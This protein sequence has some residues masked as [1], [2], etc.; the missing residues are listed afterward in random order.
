M[1]T[2]SPTRTIDTT[3]LPA[4]VKQPVATVWTKANW[5]DAWVVRVDLEVQQTADVMPPELSTATLRYRYG[6]VLLPGGSIARTQ[7]P[8]TAFG[9]YVLIRWTQPNAE[10]GLL[11]DE[12]PSAW[13]LGYADPPVTTVIDRGRDPVPPT[14][15]QTIPCFGLLRMLQLSH[16]RET[17][18]ADPAAPLGED[19]VRHPTGSTFN[20]DEA[21]NR[22]DHGA[23]DR[24]TFARSGKATTWS[25]R[26]IVKH[27]IKHHAPKPLSES[28]DP[29]P[30]ELAG[31]TQIP[32]W[33]APTMA[34][35]NRPVADL[36]DEILTESRGLAW[37]VRPV[38]EIE[39][40]VPD[41]T[42]IQI[43]VTTRIKQAIPLEDPDEVPAATERLKFVVQADP[44]IRTTL[45]DDG[46]GVVNQV[47]VEGPREIGV[48]T[49]TMLEME[50]G[51]DDEDETD[52][53]TAASDEEGYDD[54]KQFE[55]RRWNEK[56]RRREKFA[57]VFTALRIKTTWSGKVNE[58]ED[59]VFVRNE[60]EGQDEEDQ[61]EIYKPN[62]SNLVVLPDCRLRP[63][64][65]Y[66]GPINDV[67]E[68]Y[69]TKTFRPPLF[70]IEPPNLGINDP[71]QYDH[72]DAVGWITAGI[73]ADAADVSFSVSPVVSNDDGPGIRIEIGGGP[74]YALAKDFGG[75]DVDPTEPAEHQYDYQT[76]R[77]TVALL[78]DRRPNW[79]I[80]TD[81]D[82]QSLDLV[83]R[84][85]LRI[86]HPSLELVHI[87]KDTIV[88]LGSDGTP[89]TS[90]GGVLR[91][92]LP[93]LK[94]LCDLAS[95][96]LLSPSDR[97]SMT[98]G[99]ILAGVQV[100]GLVIDLDGIPTEAMIAEVRIDP[101]ATST[102]MTVTAAASRI[103]IAALLR[104]IA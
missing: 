96:S 14:G 51:W 90:D 98:S 5:S 70:L 75:L 41:V 48:C 18:L 69:A 77:C 6:F 26:D 30:W 36:L 103:D 42:E 85:I 44:H 35:D 72:L 78:G 53:R 94:A 64:V 76:V 10:T 15:V 60:V 40:G 73:A 7:P 33:D 89:I 87:A 59:Q 67:D 80:P 97:I 47:I 43:R 22:H 21:G 3:N 25:S 79:S 9:Y 81:D 88:D 49:L 62:V 82:L 104:P 31:E 58:D 39:S 92:P 102:T 86:E 57:D 13:W 16:V 24:F 32:D 61:E 83:R 101:S 95:R 54:L 1:A 29:L 65:D 27:L 71:D 93:T 19:P 37:S 28:R 100:G 34:T 38:I 8:I 66:E 84:K 4:V 20:A 74:Q 45:S 56:V 52:Y 99:R 2:P 63:S 46:V 17:V 91:D 50:D 23:G 12:S 55:K 11:D 68:K